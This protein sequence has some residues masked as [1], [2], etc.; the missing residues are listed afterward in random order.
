MFPDLGEP[1]VCVLPP[2]RRVTGFSAATLRLATGLQCIIF[3]ALVSGAI[4][5]SQ[6]WK[7]TTRNATGRCKLIERS[8]RDHGWVVTFFSRLMEPRRCLQGIRFAV[9]VVP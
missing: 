2:L 8:A 3:L 1:K 6:N 9:A 7:G 4:H 5:T